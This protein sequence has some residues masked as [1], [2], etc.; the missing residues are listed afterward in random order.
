MTYIS[1]AESR[2]KKGV[3]VLIR[4]FKQVVQEIVEARLF[5]IG[6]AAAR[7]RVVEQFSVRRETGRW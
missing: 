7:R 6:G 5:I 3:H 1:S 2:R 4:A